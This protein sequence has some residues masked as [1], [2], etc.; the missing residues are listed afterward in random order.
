MYKRKTKVHGHTK[1]QRKWFPFIFSFISKECKH[2]FSTQKP[3][4]IIFGFRGIWWRHPFFSCYICLQWP[5]GEVSLLCYICFLKTVS[6][7]AIFACLPIFFSSQKV[8]HFSLFVSLSSS[9]NSVSFWRHISCLCN[10]ALW[11]QK[12]V[13]SFL[14]FHWFFIPKV[15]YDIYSPCSSKLSNVSIVNYFISSLIAY[16]LRE[17]FHV[18]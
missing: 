9:R 12:G 14:D 4:V 17:K 18:L 15:A 10:V 1:P 7:V 11:Q 8:Y 6:D 5:F 2:S 16:S 3:S 13:N